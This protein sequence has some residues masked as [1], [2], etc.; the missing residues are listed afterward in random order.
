MKEVMLNKVVQGYLS[1]LFA[2]KQAIDT[3][4]EQAIAL[5]GQSHNQDEKDVVFSLSTDLTRLKIEE[6][7]LLT[8]KK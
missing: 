1:E 7:E 4:I 6:K 3:Q 8:T 2:Q 5:L